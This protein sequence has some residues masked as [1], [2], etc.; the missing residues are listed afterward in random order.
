M[1]SM[2]L[3]LREFLARPNPLRAG[4]VRGT[5]VVSFTNRLAIFVTS[6]I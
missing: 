4:Q 2:S 3:V 1:K 6:F 5:Y